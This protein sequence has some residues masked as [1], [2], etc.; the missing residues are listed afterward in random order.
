M[1]EVDRQSEGETPAERLTRAIADQKTAILPWEKPSAPT[2]LETVRCLDDLNMRDLF[3]PAGHRAASDHRERFVM[4]WGANHALRR[5]IPDSARSETFILFPSTRHSQRLADEFL[6]RCGALELAGRLQGWMKEGMVDGWIDR[7]P[8]GETSL[9]HVLVLRTVRDSH[10]DGRIGMA[11]LRWAS[12][13]RRKADRP[14][15]RALERRHREIAPELERRVGTIGGWGLAYTTTEEI[16]GYFR[17][18]AR[19]YLRRIFGQ[20]MLG[21]DDLIGGRRYSDWLEVLE[22]LSARAQ[23]HIA[24]AAIAK[25]RDPELDIRNLMTTHAPR[26]SFIQGVA[27]MLDADQAE[28]A[29]L[30]EAFTLSPATKAVHLDTS[31]PV[32][33]PLIDLGADQLVLPVYGLDVNP[34]L[35]LLTDLKVRHEKD[36]FRAVNAREGRWIAELDALFQGPRWRTNGRNLRL[37]RD[38]RDLTD[39]DYAVQDDRTGDIALFQLKWQHPVGADN[40]RRRNVGSSLIKESNGWIE[41]VAAWLDTNGKDELRNRLG[42][43]KPAGRIVLFVLGRYHAHVSGHDGRD[44]R[45]TWSDWAGLQRERQTRPRDGFEA[46]SLRLRRAVAKARQGGQTE[47]FAIPVAD[48]A[49]VLNPASWPDPHE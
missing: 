13:Q 28:I 25:A 23:R 32:W 38:G 41:A 45:A 2:V 34:F 44:D 7:R 6:F 35:F 17:E 22:V 24:F 15:E 1:E 48:L 14:T 46:L 43:E 37:R 39:I 11:N 27:G 47:A 12:D 40:R 18:W 9:E 16:D 42:F 33:P 4:G 30:L 26:E 19:L 21:P 36:W 8:K 49:V 20:D 5:I 31:D 10:G 29:T 3:D